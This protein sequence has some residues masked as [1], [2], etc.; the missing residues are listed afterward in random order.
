VSEAVAASTADGKEYDR[1]N[2]RVEAVV[3]IHGAEYDMVCWNAGHGSLE[4]K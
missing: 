1:A 2:S 4:E 3:L